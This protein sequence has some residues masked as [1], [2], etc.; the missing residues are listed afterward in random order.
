MGATGSTLPDKLSEDELKNVCGEQFDPVV[1]ESLKDS[2]GFVDREKFLTLVSGR[3]VGAADVEKEAETVFISYCPKGDMESKTFMKLCKDLKFL[4]KKFTGPDADLLY[5]KEKSRFGNINYAIFRRHLVPSLAAK[6]E[7]SE[8][9][10]MKKIAA[11]DGPVLT[12]TVSDNVRFHDD[13]STYTGAIA[14][15]DNFKNELS[16]ENADQVAAATKLQ[17]VQRVKQAQRQVNELKEV[18]W[19]YGI[20]A[21]HIVC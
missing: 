13:K 17:K 11:S 7:V 20:C 12:G 21:M 8:D 1:Y 4:N 3:V 6:K 14:K 9:V 5:Q 18:G 16:E 15:N 19:L 10:I 2:E